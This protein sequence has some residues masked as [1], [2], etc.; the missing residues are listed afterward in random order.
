MKNIVVP[1]L[2]AAVVAA[3]VS[4]L[5]G[6]SGYG[7]PQASSTV[8]G[9]AS[10]A[11]T[12]T[13]LAKLLAFYRKNPASTTLTLAKDAH[14]DCQAEVDSD[15]VGNLPEKWVF[16][17]VIN[18]DCELNPKETITKVKLV[19]TPSLKHQYPFAKTEVFSKK[20]QEL[21]YIHEKIKKVGADPN[22]EVDYEK[23]AYKVYFLNGKGVN[24]N[25]PILDPD[26]E[27]EGG[28]NNLPPVQKPPA[29]APATAPPAKKQ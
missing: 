5:V 2:L 25:V 9:D 10:T 4:I 28:N 27:V 23:Y 8:T 20:H 22:D 6:R 17:Y 12:A 7:G 19:F 29:P 15:P 26:L 3:A 16:W 24:P 11:P 18:E 14:G 1:A 13:A 21:I